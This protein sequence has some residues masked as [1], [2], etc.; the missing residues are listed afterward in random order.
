MAD[1]VRASARP[2]IEIGWV[3]A[4]A[5]DKV[6]VAAVRA[7]MTQ[8]TAALEAG[9]PEF[10]WRLT[11][12]HRREVAL[13]VPAEPMRLLDLGVMERDAARWDFVF[14]ITEAPLASEERPFMLGAPS[15]AVDAAV[16]STARLDPEFAFEKTARAKREAMLARRVTALSMH[17]FG[18]LNDLPHSADGADYMYP[19]EGEE[20]L[21][22]MQWLSQEGWERLRRRLV[23]VAD[24]RIEEGEHVPNRLA[25]FAKAAWLN[26]DEV[27]TGVKRIAPWRFPLRYSRL[28]TAA[29]ST[30]LILIITAEAWELGMSQPGLRVALLSLAS[31][32]GTSYYILMRQHLISRL[33][34][35]L[36]EQSVITNSSIG[37]GVLLG[38]ATTYAAL[39][40]T[41]WLAAESLFGREL[42]HHWTES[43]PRIGARHYLSLSGFVA[44][45]GL[46]IGALGASFEEETYFRRVTMLD[47]ET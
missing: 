34:H 32:F 41:T 15:Q 13:S 18:H 4:G 38:M 35:R 21:D 28:T 30:Q 8:V 24:P 46:L 44:S 17:L 36:S 3:L 2:P 40:V 1:G 11:L 43:I 23:Q 42:V 12:V 26:R 37:I 33:R 27:L 47:E 31:L 19:P 29:A 45:L 10:A 16:L 9:L 14:V 7:A 39:F 25:F 5:V 6:D 22:R 20:D